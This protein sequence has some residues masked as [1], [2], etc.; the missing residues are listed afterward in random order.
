MFLALFLGLD[1][2][3]ESSGSL[4]VF[5][6][7]LER[8]LSACGVQPGPQEFIKL[9]RGFDLHTRLPRTALEGDS[10]DLVGRQKGAT[11]MDPQRREGAAQG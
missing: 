4:D 8:R 1:Y 7:P 11:E 10:Q 3:L 5:F 6:P 2:T 9:S